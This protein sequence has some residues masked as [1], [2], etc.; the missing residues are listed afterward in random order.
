MKKQTYKNKFSKMRKEKQGSYQAPKTSAIITKAT[1]KY[2]SPEYLSDWDINGNKW[3]ITKANEFKAK[4]TKT[5]TIYEESFHNFL[6]RKGLMVEFQKI[7]Y[8]DENLKIVKFYIADIYIPKLNL[9]IEVDGGYH[10]TKTQEENDYNRTAELMSMGYKVF[11]CD[12]D[13]TFNMI[14][15]YDRILEYVNKR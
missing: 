3:F 11:R 4:L 5:A 10:Y 9:I 14:G 2:L 15:L 12:N 1:A 6:E 8:V 13:E 7:V